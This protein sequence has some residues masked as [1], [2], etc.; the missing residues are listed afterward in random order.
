MAAVKVRVWWDT[1]PG[2]TSFLNDPKVLLVY[3][4]TTLAA[5]AG[6]SNVPAEHFGTPARQ[7]TRFDEFRGSS[8]KKTPPSKAFLYMMMMEAKILTSK[9]FQRVENYED[10]RRRAYKFMVTL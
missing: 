9:L 5:E 1:L 2:P 4:A 8:K 10:L 3:K 7:S 6:L